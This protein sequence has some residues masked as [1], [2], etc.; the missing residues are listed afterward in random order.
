M[1]LY[2][3]SCFITLP[4]ICW[5]KMLPK[6]SLLIF[7]IN[8]LHYQVINYKLTLDTDCKVQYIDRLSVKIRIKAQFLDHQTQVWDKKTFTIWRKLSLM[9][10][11]RANVISMLYLIKGRAE[12]QGLS[13]MKCH[14]SFLNQSDLV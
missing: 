10:S 14:I 5:N 4:A 12:C 7:M 3:T 11:G 9:Y 1:D 2:F 13:D 8:S 6:T